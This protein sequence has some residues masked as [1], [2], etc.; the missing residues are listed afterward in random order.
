S[1]TLALRAGGA[2]VSGT[3]PFQELVYVGGG[4]TVRGYAEQRFAGRRAAYG[5]VELRLLA[6]R[7]PFG[8]VGIF[9]LADVGRVWIPGE[10]SDRWHAAAGGG[11]WQHRRAN[12]LSIAAAPSPERTAIYVRIG[13]MF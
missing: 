3:V 7:L 9:G 6:G 11:L 4:T 10:S 1:A 12:T 8:D 5:N 2:A 13:F